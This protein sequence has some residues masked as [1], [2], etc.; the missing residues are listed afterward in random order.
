MYWPFICQM[1][2]FAMYWPF[3]L[4]K[5]SNVEIGIAGSAEKDEFLNA[6]LKKL[7]PLAA[8]D[9][10]EVIDEP[11]AGYDDFKILNSSEGEKTSVTPVDTAICEEC[12]KELFD[13]DNRRYIVVGFC[14]HGYPSYSSRTSL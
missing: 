6:L 2:W 13:E 11:I 14:F 7:P 9:K 1:K 8:I 5:G 10:I 12:V 4:N 3:P